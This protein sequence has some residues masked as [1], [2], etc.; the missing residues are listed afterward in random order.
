[1]GV[2]AMAKKIKTLWG[3]DSET[4]PF[5]YG[6]KITPFLWVAISEHGD[7]YLAW[8]NDATEKFINFLMEQENAT[9]IAHNGGKFDALFLKEIIHGNM[10][11]VDGRI[12]KCSIKKGVD[13]IDSMAIL[14]MALSKI[15]S[16]SG[17][18]KEIDYNKMRPENRE[19]FKQEII[20]YAIQDVQ[21]LLSAVMDFYA[22]AGKR[23][24]TIA[25]Q[26]SAELRK[27]YPDLIK[28]DDVHHKEFSQFFFGGRVQ[29]VKKGIIKGNF[30]LFDVNSMYPAVMANCYHPHGSSYKNLDFSLSNIPE[31][32][33]GFF[34]GSLDSNGAI[35]VRQK[36]KSTPYVIGENINV[37]T[38]IH[39]LL[40]G[41][42]C[43]LI[44]NI[45]GQLIIPE[46]ITRFDQFILPHF[47]SRKRAKDIGD[48]GGDLYHKLIPNS[49]YGRF[50]MSPDGRKEVY[51]AEHGEDLTEMICHRRGR[52]K[53]AC[54]CGRGWSIGDIDLDNERYI[55]V[56]EV[57]RPWA[58]YED[59]ATGAS[60]TGAAR[61]VLMRG[62]HSAVNALYCDTDSIIC[63]SFG[64]AQGD[65]LGQWKLEA[66]FDT[67]AIAGKKLY[68]LIKNKRV[69]KS[70]SKGV[71]AC[72]SEIYLAATGDEIEIFNAAPTMRLNGTKYQAR[73]IKRT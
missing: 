44:K 61:A 43:G 51:Y 73:T 1:M 26:A 22:R 13:L 45:R 58:F 29:A 55:L 9:F 28:L 30:K 66:E 48:E 24:L 33:A 46:N 68:T 49:S 35:P 69:V 20:N 32:K 36:N 21:T 65:E 60:I 17:S 64:G 8:G 14:P 70:A 47:A 54:T 25:S 52:C 42:E 4:N 18:K 16:K 27:I 6:S 19:Q 31:H 72:P 71:R 67:A 59:V 40:A 37:K 38:T 62:L 23:R 50:A 12:L 34:I 63:E 15:K 56:K 5:E 10:L 7:R 41:I 57:S 11:L 2:N 39:E 3:Y 53:N